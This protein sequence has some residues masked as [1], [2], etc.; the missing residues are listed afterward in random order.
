MLDPHDFEL[1]RSPR[2]LREY[3]IRVKD[4]VTADA[5]ERHLGKQNS[6][7]QRFLR[8]PWADAEC[9]PTYGVSDTT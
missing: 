2:E 9:L 3:V 5:T 4:E 1:V 8:R 7:S 6:A